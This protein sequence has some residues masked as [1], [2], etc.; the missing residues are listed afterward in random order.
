MH[1]MKTIRDSFERVPMTHTVSHTRVDLRELAPSERHPLVFST[2]DQLG[3]GQAMELINDHNPKP[4]H[5][6]FMMDLPGRF[7]WDYLEQG[8]DTWRV[9]ITRLAPAQGSKQCCGACGG[10]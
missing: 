2:F 7:S 8:P 9:A 6:R 1:L 10:G 3:T 5:A 4:L